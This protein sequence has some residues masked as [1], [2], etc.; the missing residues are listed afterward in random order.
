MKLQFEFDNLKGQLDQL[1]KKIVDLH[2]VVDA[3]VES[4]TQLLTDSAFKLIGSSMQLEGEDANTTRAAFDNWVTAFARD[5]D[6]SPLLH[7]LLGKIGQVDVLDPF[8]PLVATSNPTAAQQAKSRAFAQA[9]KPEDHSRHDSG[10]YKPALLNKLGRLLR[11]ERKAHYTSAQIIFE[12]SGLFDL[13]YSYRADKKEQGTVILAVSKDKIRAISNWSDVDPSVG[14]HRAQAEDDA[15]ADFKNNNT[16]THLVNIFI[17]D[18]IKFCEP[19]SPVL[20]V[21]WETIMLA[22]KL[23]CAPETVTDNMRYRILS[24]WNN[25]ISRARSKD[26]TLSVSR[27]EALAISGAQLLSTSKKVQAAYVA[28]YRATHATPIKLAIALPAVI[29]ALSVTVL[30]FLAILGVPL[31]G[32]LEQ[33]AHALRSFGIVVQAAIASALVLVPL[34]IVSIIGAS[35]AR[36]VSFLAGRHCLDSDKCIAAL[37]D[38]YAEQKHYMDSRLEPENEGADEGITPR[39]TLSSSTP[40]PRETPRKVLG[41][42]QGSDSSLETPTPPSSGSVGSSGDSGNTSPDSL[43]S[44]NTSPDEDGYPSYVNDDDWLGA[45]GDPYAKIATQ[46]RTNDFTQPVPTIPAAAGN[47]ASA[48]SPQPQ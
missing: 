21:Y 5:V 12:G 30:I 1:I 7:Q 14:M 28:Y 40:T 11:A 33:G 17:K 10:C 45:L 42:R 25:V 26:N 37:Q 4:D 13:F 46:R 24:Q 43:D 44:G 8:V 2:T 31:P 20:G 23:K 6:F 3:F 34:A 27:I 9:Y 22:E 41:S 19:L 15:C 32:V 48:S 39:G 47:N 36:L 16:S 38:V 35:G 18:I 29:I